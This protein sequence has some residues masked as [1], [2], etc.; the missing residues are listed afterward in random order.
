MKTVIRKTKNSYVLKSHGKNMLVYPFMMDVPHSCAQ[1]FIVIKKGLTNFE[2]LYYLEIF[3]SLPLNSTKDEFY[4][5]P[6]DFILM[7]DGEPSRRII[8]PMFRKHEYGSLFEGHS[9]QNKDS[10]RQILT[11]NYG[12]CQYFNNNY[13][14][15]ILNKFKIR[16]NI[17]I[18][19]SDESLYVVGTK[20]VV[21][22]IL[23]NFK[24]YIKECTQNNQ[25]MI[26]IAF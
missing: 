5:S 25:I 16:E 21:G 3:E 11:N 10:D 14:K 1:G 2:D 12:P 9:M 23:Y 17:I 4:K 7:N 8:D 19:F 18:Q 22:N 13:S 24:K 15:K 6:F 20:Q 26:Q